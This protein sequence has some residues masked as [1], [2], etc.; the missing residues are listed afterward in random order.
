MDGIL[1]VIGGFNCNQLLDGIDYA[2]VGAHPKVLCGFSDIT[3]LANA[4]YARAGLVSYSGAH[5]STSG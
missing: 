3:A 1:S 4:L 5:Y 2:L